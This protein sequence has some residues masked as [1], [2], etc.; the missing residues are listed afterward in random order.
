MFSSIN[1]FRNRREAEWTYYF[2]RT[3]Q[4]QTFPYKLET[5]YMDDVVLINN[6]AI[7]IYCDT[8]P[9]NLFDDIKLMLSSNYIQNY[10]NLNWMYSY[11]IDVNKSYED[12]SDYIICEYQNYFN[13][14]LEEPTSIDNCDKFNV[15]KFNIRLANGKNLKKTVVRFNEYKEGVNSY[16]IRLEYSKHK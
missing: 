3:D 4:I 12:F 8:K 1:P 9:N 11:L 10:Y 7:N 16:Y 13:I 6:C 15:E 14:I 5:K 2:A